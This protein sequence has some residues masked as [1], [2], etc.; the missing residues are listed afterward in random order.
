VLNKQ[1][2]KWGASLL[3]NAYLAYFRPWRWKHWVPLKR[4]ASTR[5]HGVTSYKIALRNPERH[6]LIPNWT[7]VLFF[8][9]QNIL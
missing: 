3:L 5:L 1:H 9:L 8:H 4:W 7:M 6:R 2:A